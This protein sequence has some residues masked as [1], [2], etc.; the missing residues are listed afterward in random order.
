LLL[1][2]A[3][4]GVAVVN[5]EGLANH[6]GSS[7]GGLGLPPQPSSEHYENQL[8]EV[9]NSCVKTVN[10]EVWLEAE[11]SLVGRCRIPRALFQQMQMAPVLEISRPVKERVNQLVDVY[12]QHGS[13]ALK[14][15]TERI[16][17]RLGP[18]RTRQALDA[19][20]L[21]NWDHACR[22]MLDYYD[23]CYDHELT[24]APQ[25]HCVD[26]S[27]LTVTKAAEMLIDQQLVRPTI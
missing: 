11:S 27:G 4:R 23:R 17:R 22:A 3:K 9:L 18:Q 8:A 24:R 5:L 10:A 20:T 6:R 16:S 7:F 25:R 13:E 21:E 19:L 12:S 15:A 2:L 1:A 14:E 26:L